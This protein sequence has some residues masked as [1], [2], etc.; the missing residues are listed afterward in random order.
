MRCGGRDQLTCVC[1]SVSSV[2][3]NRNLSAASCLSKSLNVHNNDEKALISFAKIFGIPQWVDYVMTVGSCRP[4]S[5]LSCDIPSAICTSG[6]STSCASFIC[7]DSSASKLS[8]YILMVAPLLPVP[9]RRKMTREPSLKMIRT[10]WQE[11]CIIN[12]ESLLLCTKNYTLGIGVCPKII[13][14]FALKWEKLGWLYLP[15]QR[16]VYTGDAADNL[17]Y[18][19]CWTIYVMRLFLIRPK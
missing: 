18:A 9:L 6:L 17:P 16:F 13:F 14:Y 7:W 2:Y 11:K 1:E 12:V 5:S 15:L 19:W 10:P 3:L 8:M 4:V